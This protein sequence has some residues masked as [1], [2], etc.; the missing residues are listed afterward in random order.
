MTARTTAFSL[1]LCG[2]S[3]CATTSAPLKP[4]EVEIAGG[5]AT[6]RDYRASPGRLCDAEHRWLLDEVVGVNGVLRRFVE[7]VGDGD[8]TRRKRD[9]L[10]EGA[11]KLPE[12]LA[13]HEA[14]LNQLER[15]SFANRGGFTAATESGRQYVADARALLASAPA[16]IA[17]AEAVERLRLWRVNLPR[18]Q[19]EA[20]AGCGKRNQRRIYFAWEQENGTRTF[21][22]CDGATVTQ[23]HGDKPL[24]IPPP[25]APT[26]GRNVPRESDYLEAMIDYSVEMISR[27]PRVPEATASK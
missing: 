21:A 23:R 14:T 1:V 26:R 24:W 7:G 27:P 12:V 9:L 11:Q 19:Q 2:L 13:A 16:R 10:D 22:F 20:E 3:A 25:N 8:L 18:D 4:L 6:Y 17:R 5:R 15:C